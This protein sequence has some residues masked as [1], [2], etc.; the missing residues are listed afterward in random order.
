VLF[1]LFDRSRPVMP[2]MKA[3]PIGDIA[4]VAKRRRHATAS[5]D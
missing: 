2:L 1:K 4:D 3:G 5:P